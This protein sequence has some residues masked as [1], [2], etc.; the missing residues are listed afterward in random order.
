MLGPFIPV[1]GSIYAVLSMGITTVYFSLALFNQVQEWLPKQ[2]ANRH[3]ERSARGG[4]QGLLLHP[5]GRFGLGVLPVA[6]IVLLIEWLLLTGQGSFTGTFSFLG[7]ITVPALGGIFP[8]L[9]LY[10]SRRKSDYVPGVAWR[11]LGSPITVAG[12]YLIFLAAILAH[13]LWI[14]SDP[15]P[16]LVALLVGGVIAAMTFVTLRQGA[17]RPRMVVELRVDRN[18]GGRASFNVIGAGSLLPANILLKYDRAEQ[19]LQAASGDIA[20]FTGL[21]SVT[22]QLPATPA[23][24]LKIWLHQ[25]TPEGDSEGLP[26]RVEIQWDSQKQE[27]DLSS[28]NGQVVLP[29]N[30]EVCRIEI[31]FGSKSVSS[32]LAG[33]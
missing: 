19:C 14:W 8:M 30:G 7:I 15:F 1:L 23:R 16:R 18:A 25:L 27:I 6:L 20:N 24:E 17:A 12:V 3:E 13:G 28:A 9:M 2:T 11:F 22:F 32:F 10:A 29:F 26:A 31:G 4:R 33:L 21:C 5:R